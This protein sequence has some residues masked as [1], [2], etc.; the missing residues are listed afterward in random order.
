L[1][2]FELI[3]LAESI[4]IIAELDMAVLKKALAYLD[5]SSVRDIKLAVNISGQSLQNEGFINNL[6][7]LLRQ[8]GSVGK[9]VMF[10]V[11]ESAQIDNLV[12]ANTVIQHLRKNGCKV[13]LDDFGAGAASFP[14]LKALNVDFVKIDGAYVRE[15]MTSS[16]EGYILKAIAGLCSDLNASTTGEMIETEE[17]AQLLLSLG[18]ELGQ[19]YYFGKPAPQPVFSSAPPM[20]IE[21]GSPPVPEQP[22]MAKTIS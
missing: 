19:G 12:R 20:M 10:E 9:R 5:N 11:T 17:Q 8:S 16:R 15:V 1:T 6:V 7:A 14:Y 22:Q 2:P 4:G 3:T 21:A 13:G 18:V